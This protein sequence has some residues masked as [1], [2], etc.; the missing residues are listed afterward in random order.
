[1]KRCCIFQIKKMN[2]F[3]NYF[4]ELEVKKQ[5]NYFQYMV[6][7]KTPKEIIHGI[8]ADLQEK[9][10]AL[11]IPI[12][13]IGPNFTLQNENEDWISL[14]SYI[15]KKNVVLTFYRGDWCGH[16]R[17]EMK[18]INENLLE[19][20][21]ENAVVLAI[22]P[23]TVEKAIKLQKEHAY[24]FTLLSDPTFQTIRDYKIDFAVHQE[25]QNIYMNKFFLDI[26]KLN[27]NA[28]WELPVPATFIIDNQGVVRSSFVQMDYTRRMSASDIIAELKR[29]NRS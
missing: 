14:N 29:I 5:D 2:I 21:A 7:T 15:G 1:M 17:R 19:I 23:Q 27:S 26:P 10:I 12:G 20:Q 24:E 4:P 11:G 9:G 16:C 13:A 28:G 3:R 6:E 22:A 8:N 25:I 18:D